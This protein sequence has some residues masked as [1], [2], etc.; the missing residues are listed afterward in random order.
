MAV[1]ESSEERRAEAIAGR[2]RPKSNSDERRCAFVVSNDCTAIKHD[3]AY[4]EQPHAWIGAGHNHGGPLVHQRPKA[5]DHLC[6]I[7]VAK[8]GE[9]LVGEDHFGIVDQRSGK[10]DEANF[11]T[12]EHG[13]GK[14]NLAA[15]A[16]PASGLLG[17]PSG[18][19]CTDARSEKWKLHVFLDRQIG[20]QKRHLRE[21]AV[22]DGLSNCPIVVVKRS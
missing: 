17:G 4:P 21:K 8:T 7:G 16:N 1:T 11:R 18:K 14:A 15:Q 20:D 5:Q 12:R 10:G 22:A 3:V 9:R 6:G 2:R 19:Q 13:G